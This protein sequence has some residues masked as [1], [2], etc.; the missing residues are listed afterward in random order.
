MFAVVEAVH[1]LA[2]VTL[3]TYA[4][5]GRLFVGGFVPVKV[6]GGVPPVVVSVTLVVPPKQVIGAKLLVIARPA[7]GCV[8]VALTVVVQRFV[9]VIVTV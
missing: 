4:P 8:M 2:S 6:Y 1:P 5:A 9:S 3:Y 7:A